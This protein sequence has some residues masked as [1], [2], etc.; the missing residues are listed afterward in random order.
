MSESPQTIRVIDSHTAGEPT[1]VVVDG[2]PEFTGMLAT[3]I[4][5]RDFLQ[6]K[7]D[8]LRTAVVSEPRG[9]EA[10]V[11]AVLVEPTQPDCLAGVVFFNN[12]GYLHGCLHGTI[13]V[14]VTLAHLGRLSEGD[15]KI[16]TP[17]GIV[18]VRPPVEGWVTVQNVRS[19]RYAAAVPVEVEGWGT[20]HGDVAWG[21]NW[22]FLIDAGGTV[23]V[24][25]ANLDQLTDF[26]CAVREALEA[27]GI[28]G[29]DDGEIDHIEIFGPPANDDA[30]SKNFVLCPGR[31]YDR[32]PCGTGTSAKLACL[33]ADGKLQ[34]G[35]TWRQAGI[36]DTVF[37]CTLE[38][39][40]EGG[41]FPTIKGRAFV[42]GV[43]ELIVHPDD[44]FRHGIHHAR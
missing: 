39:T 17:T 43:S 7:H 28:T 8:W 36:L 44:P 40:P 12:V 30:D 10:M 21:G 23:A 4:E 15:N 27:N 14:A 34:P 11:G 24:D 19:F 38:K 16:E 37:E 5:W 13:G 26:T 33:H 2:L 32:S 31:E 9:H 6:S 25:F 41:I 20:V 3:A 1:R 35:Q 18:T 29:E 42:T 22:F